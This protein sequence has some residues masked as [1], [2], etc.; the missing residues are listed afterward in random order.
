MAL[1]MFLQNLADRCRRQTIMKEE[2]MARSEI[3]RLPME[4]TSRKEVIIAVFTI[5]MIAVHLIARFAAGSLI[6]M[7][8]IPLY[9]IPL[10]VALVGGGLF[11]LFDL[12]TK[13][14]QG[15]FGLDL[16]AGISI[17]TSAI[18]GEYLAGALVVLMLSGGEAL[19]AY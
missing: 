14:L 12:L 4:R 19:E 10:L 6:E 7:Q 3:T 13:L 2:S 17:V 18:L 8:G 16:L 1:S 15:E 9:Q 5:V 11:L